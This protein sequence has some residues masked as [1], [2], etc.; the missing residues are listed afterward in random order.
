MIVT[1]EDIPV[2]ANSFLFPELFE[3][4]KYAQSWMR[5]SVLDF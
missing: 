5:E 1:Q 3:S 2:I 4:V